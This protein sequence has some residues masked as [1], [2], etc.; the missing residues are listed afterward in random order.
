ML[1]RMVASGV[2]SLFMVGA[3]VA[4]PVKLANVIEL[5]GGGAAVGQNW[6]D[7]V[8]LAV[9]EI[10]AAGGLL[11][12]PI[13]LTNYDT[14]SDPVTSRGQVQRAIDDG[15]FAI[16]GP[17]FSGSAV[18]NMVVAQAAGVP[19]LT[20]A[21]APSITQ[22][23]NPY[24][25]RTSY[26]AQKAMPKIAHYLQDRLSVEK[27]GIIWVNSEY[28]KG[29]RDPF[30]AEMEQSGIA[31]TLEAVTE[32]NQVDFASD[33]A[34][35]KAS[36]A[37]AL[38]VYLTEEESARL[39]R[40]LHRQ[41]VDIP[42]IGEGGTFGPN[43]IR[44]AGDAAEGVLAHVPLTPHADV[45]TIAAFNDAFVD[46]Y[47]YT[48]DHNAMKGYI[49]VYIVKHVVETIGVADR[50]MFADTL[51]GLTI[52]AEQEPGVLLD[53][54]FDETGEVARE[55]FMTIVENGLNVVIETVP[56]N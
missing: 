33:V 15:A 46:R 31:V 23:G 35:I 26:G 34:R 27:V 28:G 18:V 7:A 5:S 44:L 53:I 32:V 30:M 38:F 11:G 25:F 16:L 12:E 39:L 36:D 29:G 41:G 21:E 3:A 2:V 56:A 6:R 13:E 51:R 4:E 22:M 43:V 9:D 40:E 55:S 17:I 14:Q 47:N 10:N 45:A 20:G 49:G 1:N 54:T 48:P 8:V 42:V 50:E 19:Q 52:T 37:E 24:I